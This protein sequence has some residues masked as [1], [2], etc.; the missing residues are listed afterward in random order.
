MR[1][2]SGAHADLTDVEAEMFL[3]Y[4][5][6]RSD[7]TLNRIGRAQL[8]IFP[9]CHGTVTLPHGLVGSAA[10]P[11]V[12]SDSKASNCPFRLRLAEVNADTWDVYA[13]VGADLTFTNSV[14]DEL[15]ANGNAKGFGARFR[16]LC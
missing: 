16:S 1:M 3:V 7:V 5:H 4:V 9:T 6:G 12:S 8:A 2:G 13:G 10:S 11:V 14:I 15:N